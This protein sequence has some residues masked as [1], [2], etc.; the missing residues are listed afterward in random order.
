MDLKNVNLKPIGVV[1]N[2]IDDR[3]RMTVLGGPSSVELFPEYSEGLLHFEKHSHLW[4]LVWLH[5]ADR[6][7]LRVKPRGLKDVGDE[8]MHGV[9]A[10]R[11]PARP[12]PIGLTAAKVLRRE[13]NRIEFDR[14]DFIDGTPVID[15]KPYYVT[16]DMIFSARNAQ[17][18]KT[19]S[20]EAV[21]ESLLMQGEMFAGGLSP[22]TEQAARMLA[23]FRANVLD[24]IDPP[25]WKIRVPEGA[26]GL[27][28]AFLGMTRVRFGDGGIAFHDRQVVLIEAGGKMKEYGLG[29]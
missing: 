27:A 9:F 15:L 4:V 21:R 18:G 17:V 16:R 11:S 14:L 12:N 22:E 3:K 5:T 24:F 1:R 20:E 13:G 10:V 8:G 2:E 28:D 23:D 26:P 25:S 19:A 6:E 7:A 29:A